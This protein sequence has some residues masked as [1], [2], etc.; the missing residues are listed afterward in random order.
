MPNV[1]KSKFSSLNFILP[2]KNILVLF[3]GYAQSSFDQMA[4][5]IE[6]NKKLEEAR[7]IL[8]PRLMNGALA[9]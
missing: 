9:A 7:D 2:D 4:L 3:N 6:M 8:L 1:N 5:L